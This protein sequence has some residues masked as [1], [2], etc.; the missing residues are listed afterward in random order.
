MRRVLWRA[1]AV[2]VVLCGAGCAAPEAAPAPGG[3][4][5][6]ISAGGARLWYRVAGSGRAGAPPVVFLHGGPGQGSEHFDAL[7]GRYLEP[8]LRMVYFDQRGSGR[9]ERPANAD[10]ALATLVEDVERL[11]RDLG[12]PRLVLVGHSFGAILGLEYAARH[13]GNVAGLV[14][15]AGLWDAPYQCRLRLERMA[16]LHPAAVARVRGDSLARDGSRRSDCELEGEALS[17]S[18]RESY[19]LSAMFPD[20]RIAARMDSVNQAQDIRNTGELGRALFRAGLLRYRFSEFDRISMPALVV[21]GAHDGA[22]RPEG[23]RTLADRLPKARFVEFERS[24]HF[25]YLDE[26]ERFARELTRFVDTLR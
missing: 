23:L 26:P 1:S 7:A 21:A 22:A 10:Y 20:P 2:L 19:N 6:E 18:E 14:V 25:V 16:E 9:S 3:A 13:P 4:A 8:T 12:V 5:H 15:V 24:G 17:G 11:R